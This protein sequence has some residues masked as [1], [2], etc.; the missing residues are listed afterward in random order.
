MVLKL[1]HSHVMLLCSIIFGYVVL[2]VAVN[3]SV[4][5]QTW[6]LR[7]SLILCLCRRFPR[8]EKVQRDGEGGSDQQPNGHRAHPHETVQSSEEPVHCWLRLV[9]LPVRLT[10]RLTPAFGDRN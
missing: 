1:H 10:E 9:A 6:R 4:T 5:V 8:G 3:V 7:A 2:N